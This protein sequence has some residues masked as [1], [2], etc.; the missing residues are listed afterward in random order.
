[1]NGSFSSDL[2][3][4]MKGAAQPRTVHGTLGHCGAPIHLGTVNGT[5]RVVSLR[6][7]V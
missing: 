4:V 2:P 3:M 7:T 6:S 1:M 5:I